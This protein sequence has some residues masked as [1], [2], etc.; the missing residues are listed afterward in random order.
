MPA[1]KKV[2]KRPQRAKEA[3]DKLRPSMPRSHRIG[4]NVQ[5]RKD[6][7]KFL[8]WP[9]YVKIQRQRAVLY[10]R[11]K[12]PPAI[13][14]FHRTLPKDQRAEV[15]RLL[16]KYQ[17]RTKAQRHADRVER[18][19]KIAAKETVE[20]VKRE[21][22]VQFGLNHVTTLIEEKQAKLV[23]IAH[24][25]DPIELVLWLPAL[26]RKM[27][28]PYC[29]VTGKSTLGQIVHQKTATCLA[30]TSVAAAD[31]RALERCV[32]L[33]RASYNDNVASVGKWGGGTM[34]LKTQR[35]IEAR[36]KIARE[37]EKKKAALY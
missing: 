18:A 7:S 17:P 15:F 27:D 16:T 5:P 1:R 29:I 35:K 12:V 20:N 26:C 21:N 11:L 31:E 3:Q 22:V 2:T 36:E 9:R 19:K 34:G 8:K 13:N 23:V 37:E 25:V 10:K 24:D 14:Q 28:V 30:V 4:G 33:A 6:L 32:E